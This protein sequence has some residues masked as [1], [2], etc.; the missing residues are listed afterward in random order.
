VPSAP[1]LLLPL[2]LPA[3]VVVGG[4]PPVS[5][6]EEDELEGVE[7]EGFGWGVGCG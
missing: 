2:L 7:V 4:V 1:L 5:D 6:D 3:P